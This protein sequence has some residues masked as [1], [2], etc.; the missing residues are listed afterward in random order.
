MR[1]QVSQFFER[2]KERKKPIQPKNARICTSPISPLPEFSNQ[3]QEEEEKKQE[4]RKQTKQND[5]HARTSTEI[6][7]RTEQPATL[8]NYFCN[9]NAG[10]MQAGVAATFLKIWN[11]SAL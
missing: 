7:A 10:S 5:M 4:K 11:A 3:G 9:N 6:P 2:K 8:K 1:P